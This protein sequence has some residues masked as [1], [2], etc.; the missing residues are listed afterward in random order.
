MY[1]R[2]VSR[3][4]LVVYNGLGASDGLHYSAECSDVSC[5]TTTPKQA[6]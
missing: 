1:G 6:K 4:I 2:Y 3:S 5:R